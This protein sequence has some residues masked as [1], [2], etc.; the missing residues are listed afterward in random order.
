MEISEIANE[1]QITEAA[2]QQHISRGLRKLMRAG[3]AED[4]TALV[5]LTQRE[6][7]GQPNIRCGSIE[8]R[9]EWWPFYA[10]KQSREKHGKS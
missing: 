3:K 6:K 4:F 5:Q 10:G 9:P 7:A 2:V 8:C 1:L